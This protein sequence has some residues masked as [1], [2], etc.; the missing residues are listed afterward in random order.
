MSSERAPVACNSGCSFR[1][2]LDLTK[3]AVAAGLL[4]A[5]WRYVR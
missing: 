5:L 3:I 2:S 4:P 1:K